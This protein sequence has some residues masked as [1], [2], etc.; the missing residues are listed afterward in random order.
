MPY[1]CQLDNSLR[2]QMTQKSLDV[3]PVKKMSNSET[4]VSWPNRILYTFCEWT[5]ILTVFKLF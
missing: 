5:V 2:E 1:G 3:S 4:N